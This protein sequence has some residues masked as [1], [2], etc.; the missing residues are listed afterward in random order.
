LIEK[1]QDPSSSNK[2]DV[3]KRLIQVATNCAVEEDLLSLLYKS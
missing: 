3:P 1:N 2:Q